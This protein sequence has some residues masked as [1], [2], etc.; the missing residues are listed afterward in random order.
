MG[1]CSRDNKIKFMPENKIQ[2]VSGL[3]EFKHDI[4]DFKFEKVFGI[5]QDIPD[6]NFA[7]KYI[8]NQKNTDFCVAFSTTE[9]AEYLDDIELDPLWFFSKIKQEEGDYLSFGADFKIAGKAAV[10]WG[11]LPQQNAP[12]SIDNRSRNEL[13]NWENYNKDL[14]VFAFPYRK[15]SYFFV[16]AGYQTTVSAM[17]INKTPVV[18][19]VNWQE[20]WWYSENGII[21]DISKSRELGNHAVKAFGKK[22]INKKR[23]VG[24]QNSYGESNGENGLFWFSEEVFD[25]YFF[26]TPMVIVD[27]TPEEAKQLSWS[28]KVR[29]YDLMIKTIQSLILKLNELYDRTKAG[30]GFK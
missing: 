29:F 13:A 25:K 23:Y 30:L 7:P 19:G 5:A 12:F 14:E 20:D 3:R 17:S 27:L 4:R 6:F 28:N 15:K 1:D 26:M 24:I 9:V 11:F 8:K 2:F 22:T 16:K 18:V 10:K 21:D